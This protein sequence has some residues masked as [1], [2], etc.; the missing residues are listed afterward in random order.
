[1]KL[2]RLRLRFGASFICFALGHRWNPYIVATDRDAL[3]YRE[4]C[5]RCDARR[6]QKERD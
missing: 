5:L 6:I 3:S 4:R 1:M 2:P